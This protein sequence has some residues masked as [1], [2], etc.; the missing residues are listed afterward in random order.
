MQFAQTK[1]REFIT[2]I[3]GAAAEVWPFAARAQQPAMPVVGFVTPTS[4]DTQADR[5][6]AFRQGLKENGFVEGE[7]VAITYLWAENQIDRIPK[8]VAD[9]VQRKATVIAT[10]GDQVALGAKATTTQIPI[11]FVSGEDPVRLG[12]V[13]SLARPGGNMTGVNIFVNEVA[14][15]RL[16]L[17]RELMPAAMRV[18]V[19]VNPANT[20]TEA[21][22][23]DVESAARVM[24]LQARVLNANTSGDIDAAFATLVSERLDAIFVGGAPL[25][26]S[27]RVQLI[28]LAT[29]HAIPATYAGRQFP[30]MAMV[31]TSRMHGVRSVSM[32]VTSSR[33]QSPPTC[34]SCRRTSLSLSSILT[35]L[36]CSVL[37]CR[38]S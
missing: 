9:L 18:G 1:R 2:L 8:L 21:I 10:V 12:L 13:N 6:R 17:L 19:L 38:R 15:K 16:E 7:N 36:R 23:R 27:Q 11:V 25:F 28:L 4:A 31:P 35:R 30:E 5:L 37:S 34:R 32:L 20:S 24:R 26:T 33:V 22:L 3:G 29:R 14:A